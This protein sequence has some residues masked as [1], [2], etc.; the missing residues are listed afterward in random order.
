MIREFT[1]SEGVGPG[2]GRALD[3]SFAGLGLRGRRRRGLVIA[4]LRVSK[5][6]LPRAVAIAYIKPSRARRS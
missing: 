2:A 6:R 1:P 4:V 3:R 5:R